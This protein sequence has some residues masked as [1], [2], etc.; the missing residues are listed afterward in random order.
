MKDLFNKL[1]E[2]KEISYQMHLKA[3]NKHYATHI[4]LEKYHDDLL[5]Q[6][7]L[8]IEVYQGQYGL[9]EDF[10][11]FSEVDT[12]DIV[13]YYEDF[14]KYLQSSRDELVKE[15]NRH[16]DTF[17]DELLIITYLLIYKLKFLK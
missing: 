5:E 8:I 15:E 3:K 7:D 13:K 14:A 12:S 6:I 1:L 17:F 9:I 16:F 2:V 4:A 10:G 11:V